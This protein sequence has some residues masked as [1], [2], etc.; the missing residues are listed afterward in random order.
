MGPG[1][2]MMSSGESFAL[3]VIEHLQNRREAQ[4]LQFVLRQL[5]FADGREVLDRDVVMLKVAA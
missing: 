1:V 5:E 4:L 2:L 3:D